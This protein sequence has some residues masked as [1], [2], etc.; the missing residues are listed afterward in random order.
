MQYNDD[1]QKLILNILHA[2]LG[3]TPH[4]QKLDS[5][6]ESITKGL[7]S[8]HLFFDMLTLNNAPH[9]GITTCSTIGLS[10]YELRDDKNRKPPIRIELLSVLRDDTDFLKLTEDAADKELFYEKQLFYTACY[11]INKNDYIA[12]GDTW[13]NFFTNTYQVMYDHSDMEHVFFM[14]PTLLSNK[15]KPV[16]IDNQQ[17]NWLL[18]V[19][20]SEAELQYCIKNSP[21]ALNDL[22]ITNQIDVS[23]LFRKS[24]I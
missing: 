15:L 24:V 22:L 12:Y 4:I 14:P 1:N 8:K 6:Q 20:I 5:E 13:I 18:C 10:E 11:L 9:D 23:D 16:T 21:D 7:W 3:G 19:P 17:I 2:E